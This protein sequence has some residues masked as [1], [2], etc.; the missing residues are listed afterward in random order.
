MLAFCSV[1]S[2]FRLFSREAIFLIQD[3]FPP[4]FYFRVSF[5]NLKKIASIGWTMSEIFSSA[6]RYYEILKV[7][8][9]EKMFSKYLLFVYY[10][11]DLFS[12]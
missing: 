4:T 7:K 6:F 11:L 10:L 2:I 3:L 9:L 12:L 8:H 5:A 1:Y